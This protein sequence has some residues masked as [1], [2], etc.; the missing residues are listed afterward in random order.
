MNVS[1][2]KKKEGKEKIEEGRCIVHGAWYVGHIQAAAHASGELFAGSQF[3]PVCEDVG[4][5]DSDEKMLSIRVITAATAAHGNA[6][7]VH[8][9]SHVSSPPLCFRGAG[10][11][12]QLD[13]TYI[14]RTVL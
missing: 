9:L 6:V 11:V 4:L 10:G 1:E 7:G 5:E 13:R 8:P 2:R 3:A 12:P 14:R